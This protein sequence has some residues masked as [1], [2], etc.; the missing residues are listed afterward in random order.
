MVTVLALDVF[1]APEILQGI[2]KKWWA[3][4]DLNL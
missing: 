3:I 4:Q 1:E 2:E